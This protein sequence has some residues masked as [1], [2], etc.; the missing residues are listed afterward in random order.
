MVK[1]PRL[2]EKSS[3]FDEIWHTIVAL[4]PND[5]DVTQL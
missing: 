3:D 2:N 1:S 4:E 5:D